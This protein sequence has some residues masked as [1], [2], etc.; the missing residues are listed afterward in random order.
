MEQDPT[1]TELILGGV[2]AAVAAGVGAWRKWG[3]KPVEEKHEVT[4]H[5][6]IRKTDIEG[7]RS[8][9]EAGAIRFERMQ[10]EIGRLQQDVSQLAA[11]SRELENTLS[12][13][14]GRLE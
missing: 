7:I 11:I 1:H 2:A 14:L 10:T 6:C 9:L 8:R 3:P 4:E 12:R 13:L 5:D